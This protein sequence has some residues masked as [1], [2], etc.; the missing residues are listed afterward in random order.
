MYSKKNSGL[1]YQEGT[2]LKA[3]S[4]PHLYQSSHLSHQIIS[5]C[6]LITKQFLDLHSYYAESQSLEDIDT[7]ITYTNGYLS[8]WMKKEDKNIHEL[9]TLATP[10]LEEDYKIIKSLTHVSISFILILQD[11]IKNREKSVQNEK[12]LELI[13]HQLDRLKNIG[14]NKPENLIVIKKIT[15]YLNEINSETFIQKIQC[16]L[17]RYLLEITSIHEKL[18]L[19]ATQIQLEGI[20]KIMA[21]WMLENRIQ[22]NTTYVLISCGKGPRKQLIEKQYMEWLYSQQNL[23]AQQNI[24]CVEMLPEQLASVTGSDLIAFLKKQ[25]LNK[26]IGKSILGDSNAMNKD[27]LGKYAPNVLSALCP[28]QTNQSKYNKFLQKYSF[29]TVIELSTK[30]LLQPTFAT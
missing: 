5:E 6:D 12:D 27:V 26:Q 8:L 1:A 4:L 21:Q 3:K 15:H 17:S 25:Q 7:I 2:F 10:A 11:I 24:I 14:D 13:A 19:K 20:H 23:D 30:D 28:M 16:F 18:A 22:L 9:Q 29:F